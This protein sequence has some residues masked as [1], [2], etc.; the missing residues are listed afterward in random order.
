MVSAAMVSHCRGT[1]LINARQPGRGA[2]RDGDARTL[3]TP[4]APFHENKGVPRG[5]VL[6]EPDGAGCEGVVVATAIKAQDRSPVR[7]GRA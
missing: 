7:G 6:K 4:R 3:S 2:L 5:G 1:H